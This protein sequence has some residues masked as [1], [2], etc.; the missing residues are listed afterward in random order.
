MLGI[1]NPLRAEFSVELALHVIRYLHLVSG[2]FRR[3]VRTC[4][5]PNGPSHDIELWEGARK[6]TALARKID[7]R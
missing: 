3:G 5:R 2:L 7:R 6:I 4:G 1:V